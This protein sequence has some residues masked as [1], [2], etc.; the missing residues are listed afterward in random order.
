MYRNK[1]VSAV[2]PCYNE[3]EGIRYV[4][5]RMPPFVDEIV[6]VDNNST[7]RTGEVARSLGAAVVLEKRKGY[8]RAYK[9]GIPA[10]K[11]EIIVT[12]DGDGSYPLEEIGPLI[13]HLLDRKLDFV[14]ASRF[15]L[16][17]RGSM[18]SMNRLGN[19]VLTAATFL[20]FFRSI[21]DSQSGMWAFYASAYPGIAPAS[22]GMAFSEELKIEAML[23]KNVRFGEYHIDYH[24][25]IG[26]VKL[27]MWKD[28]IDNLLFLVRRRFG[29]RGGA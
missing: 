14:S 26:E 25:R 6:V 3:E 22:D 21:R 16:Q 19:W 7:D 15:P 23:A 27:N 12:L 8:G 28:G 18:Q 11:S 24:A 5:E 20:L 1:T 17:K 9:T 29:G 2:I 13:D 10:A 4:I